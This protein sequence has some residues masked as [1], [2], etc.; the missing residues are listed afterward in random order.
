MFVFTGV[1]NIEYLFHHTV[2]FPLK[3]LVHTTRQ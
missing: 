2:E 1:V 3:G